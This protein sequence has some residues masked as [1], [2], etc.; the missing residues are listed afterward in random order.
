MLL[1]KI[2]PHP[3]DMNISFKEE[4][5]EYTIA[6]M[7][8]KPTS[9]TTVVHHYF[10]EFEPDIVINKMMASR[11]WPNS[12][13]YGMT[14]EAIKQ[15]WAT[16][17]EEAANLGTI[18]HRNIELFLNNELTEDPNTKEFNMFTNFWNGLIDMYPMLRPYRTEWLIY[19]EDVRIAGSIDCVLS[20]QYGN[21]IILDW[22]RSKE[23]KMD[24]RWEKGNGIFSNYQNCNHLTYSLQLNLYRHILEN[25]YNKRVIYM[26][27]VVLHPNQETYLCYPVNHIELSSV[28]S[29]INS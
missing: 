28:W 7:E 10:P 9:V 25:K 8:T 29:N 5:H 2:N 24:N 3:R 19:D 26:M 6:N 1:A 23:I 16:A 4:G 12:K 18:M 15:Q 11:N 17:G 21:L 14:R 22:K 13:Y 20:D 27:L